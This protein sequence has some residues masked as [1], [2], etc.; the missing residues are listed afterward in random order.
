MK[1]KIDCLS[2]KLTQCYV[3]WDI[4]SDLWHKEWSTLSG[5]EIQRVALAAACSF[6]PDILL[7]D[8]PTSA[9]DHQTCLRVEETLKKR[10]C[11]WVTHDFEQEGRVSNAGSIT[12]TALNGLN[13]LYTNNVVIQS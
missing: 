5:G 3:S 11:I 4:Q 9:L 8:E 1:I 2:S 6:H 7:L 13:N 12:L 10:T